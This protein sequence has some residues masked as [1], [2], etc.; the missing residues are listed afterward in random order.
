VRRLAGVDG[1]RRATASFGRRD[2]DGV[3]QG[4]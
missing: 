3:D 1:C 2:R 4:A